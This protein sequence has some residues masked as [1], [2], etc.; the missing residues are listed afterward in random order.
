MYK[1]S[2]EF[3]QRGIFSN[4]DVTNSLSLCEVGVALTPLL[5]IN[6]IIIFYRLNMFP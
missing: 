2:A 3:Y 6:I 4:S 1:K 5:N